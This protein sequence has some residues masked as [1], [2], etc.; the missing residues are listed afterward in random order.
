MSN[1]EILH[2]LLLKKG[3]KPDKLFFPVILPQYH[4]TPN[5]S[6]MDIF[7]FSFSLTNVLSHFFEMII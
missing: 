3:Q 6:A 5:E 1:L 7:G 4:F 2:W